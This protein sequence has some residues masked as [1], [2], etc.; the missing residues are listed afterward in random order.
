MS[1]PLLLID[2][3]NLLFQ[4]NFVGRGRGPNWLAKARLRLLRR[5]E[6][7][8]RPEQ[9]RGTHIIFDAPKVGVAPQEECLPSGVRVAYA[10]DHAE[11]D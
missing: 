8:L 5:I 6:Q 2:G 7:S 1:V 9:L 10:V 11:A 3:Y 4:S